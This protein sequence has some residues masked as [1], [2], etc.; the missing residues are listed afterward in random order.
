M[1]NTQQFASCKNRNCYQNR[2]FVD[3]VMHIFCVAYSISSLAETRDR[4]PS[5]FLGKLN[6]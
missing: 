3:F 1:E 5:F 2:F 4:V 6:S